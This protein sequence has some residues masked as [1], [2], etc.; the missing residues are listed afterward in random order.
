[1]VLWYLHLVSKSFVGRERIE[2]F[3]RGKLGSA[4]TV[5]RVHTLIQ[6]I[7]GSNLS[8][9]QMAETE[10]KDLMVHLE[11]NMDLSTMEQGIKLVGTSLAHKTLNKWS[12][13]NILKASW[14]ELGEIEIKWVKCNTFIITVQD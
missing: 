8:L 14:K 7:C 1:M 5:Y 9:R 4:T 2:K 3:Q 12:V 13:R 10:V 11:Q 6:P